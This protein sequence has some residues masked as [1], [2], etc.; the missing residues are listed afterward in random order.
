MCFPQNFKRKKTMDAITFNA[1]TGNHEACYAIKS[2]WHGKG[3]VLDFVPDS[4]TMIRESNLAN[5]DLQLKEL[6]TACG[7]KIPDR[8]AV[9]RG[10]TRQVIG[11]V[12]GRY[13]IL[14]NEQTFSFLDSLHADGIMRYESAFSLFDS[15]RV[16][17]VAKLPSV[18]TLTDDDKLYRYLMLQTSHDGSCA[19]TITPTVIRPVCYNTVSLALQEGKAATRSIKHTENMLGKLEQVKEYLIGF[20]KQFS[21]FADGAKILSEKKYTKEMFTKYIQELFPM[22]ADDASTRAKNVYEETRENLITSYKHPT[23]NLP[24]MVGTV[25]QMFNV[26]TFATDHLSNGHRSGDTNLDSLLFGKKNTLKQ[27]AFELALTMVS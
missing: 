4:E 3:K 9:V 14:Q 20:D 12:G 24:S 17:V 18:D 8:F 6:Q 26:V 21:Q 2:A 13:K 1:I 10:D 5:W 11:T 25:W 23:N 7:I 19:I 22:P 27:R 16:V 15:T